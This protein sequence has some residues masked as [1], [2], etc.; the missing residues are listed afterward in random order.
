MTYLS[1]APL[2]HTAPLLGV[3]LTVRMGGTVTAKA[4][5]AA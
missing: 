5:R 1:P 4:K 3:A 2:Y